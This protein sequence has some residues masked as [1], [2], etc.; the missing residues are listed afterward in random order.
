MFATATTHTQ[1]FTGVLHSLRSFRPRLSFTRGHARL[2]ASE[3][4]ADQART[5]LRT[6]DELGLL[7]GEG[8]VADRGLLEQAARLRTGWS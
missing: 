5:F 1:P 8:C 2:G 3:S 7:S 4:D 6:L